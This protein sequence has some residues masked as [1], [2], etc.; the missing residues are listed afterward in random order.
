MKETLLPY[1]PAILAVA[2]AVILRLAFAKKR[3][4]DVPFQKESRRKAKRPSGPSDPRKIL[5]RG[6][7]SRSRHSQTTPS[8]TG[9]KTGGCLACYLSG[10]RQT[11]IIWFEAQNVTIP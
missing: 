9:R 11:N 8:K 4:N 1:A 3:V 7:M 6:P 5:G 10:M 2:I